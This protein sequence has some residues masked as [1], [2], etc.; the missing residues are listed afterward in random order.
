MVAPPGSFDSAFE[1]ETPSSRCGTILHYLRSFVDR[2][3]FRSIHHHLLTNRSHFE[4]HFGA[5]VTPLNIVTTDVA[6]RTIAA[7]YTATAAAV[8]A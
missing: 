4:N 2:T 5:F 6:G 1:S 8:T 3:D 7:A